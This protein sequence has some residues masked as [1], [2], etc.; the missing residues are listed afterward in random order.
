MRTAGIERRDRNYRRGIVRQQ[1]LTAAGE[2]AK[3]R[4]TAC[5][6][7][8]PRLGRIEQQVHRSDAKLGVRAFQQKIDAWPLDMTVKNQ[9]QR[10]VFRL[11]TA[12]DM[13]KVPSLASPPP[14]TA[15]A[16]ENRN[17]R[18]VK[19]TISI[20]PALE[21]GCQR[22]RPPPDSRKKLLSNRRNP[23]PSRADDLRAVASSARHDLEVRHHVDDA[24]T[25]NEVALHRAREQHLESPSHEVDQDRD[26][27]RP[28]GAREL[29]AI[30]PNKLRRQRQ[31]A[32]DPGIGKHR[33]CHIAYSSNCAR[34]KRRIGTRIGQGET[35]PLPSARSSLK[36]VSSN[37]T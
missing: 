6:I 7:S 2:R 10:P 13:R 27:A 28:F 37:F 3:F 16:W 9:P 1:D 22:R 24:Q 18:L 4:S 30:A 31:P 11:P 19:W 17:R 20:I 26:F 14:P 29:E 15:A 34:G 33:P 5:A 32:F 36:P 25:R 12:R 8:E 35:F 23:G 21:A